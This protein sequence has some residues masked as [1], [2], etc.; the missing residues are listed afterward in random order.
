MSKYSSESEE[1]YTFKCPSCKDGSIKITKNLYDLPDKDKML[2]IKFECNK[3]N[4]HNNDIIPYTTRIEPGILT[5]KV[6]NEEDLKSKIYR[7]PTSKLEIPELELAVEPG[8]SASFY[9]TNIQGILY[10]FENAVLIHK[11][12]LDK[13]NKKR[14]EIDEIL[15]SLRKAIDGKFPFTLIIT[16]H[17]GGSYII[18]KDESKLSFTKLVILQDE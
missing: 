13:D 4:F 1:E 2:I 10:R 14:Q 7:S 6:R 18:P 8:P 16:D 3:C 17:S 9:F 5:L 11:N 15:D 12:S